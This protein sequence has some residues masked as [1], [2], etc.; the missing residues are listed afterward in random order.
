[1]QHHGQ[2]SS[3]LLCILQTSMAYLHVCARQAWLLCV[4]WPYGLLE[5]HVC[6]RMPGITYRGFVTLCFVVSLDGA[7]A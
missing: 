5:C 4:V 2:S 7:N 1:M 3:L 6:P